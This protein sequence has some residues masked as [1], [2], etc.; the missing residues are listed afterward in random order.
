MTLLM[1]HQVAPGSAQPSAIS[2]VKFVEAATAAI[3]LREKTATAPPVRVLHVF[4]RL[5]HGGMERGVLKLVAGLD[6][7]CFEQRVCVL[8]GSDESADGFELLRRDLLRAPQELKTF[9]RILWLA[10]AM[11]AYKP[12]IVHSRNWGAVEAIVAARLARVPAV[13]HS[14]HGYEVGTL[15]GLPL[16]RRM[17]RWLLYRF[18]D[19]VFCVTRELRD[20]HARQAATSA[21]RIRVIYNAV[22]TDR[23]APDPVKRRALRQKLN[24]EN[25]F[26]VGA[27]GR[28][29]PIKNYDLLLEALCLLREKGID[30]RG[31]LVGDGPELQRLRQ[32]VSNTPAL[33]DRVIFLGA[34]NSVADW[35]NAM[36]VFVQPSLAEGMSNTLLEAMAAGLPVLATNAGGNPEVMEDG[37]QG[38]LFP[39]RDVQALTDHL[40]RLAENDALRKQFGVAARQHAVQD[41]GLQRMLDNYSHLY[42]TLASRRSA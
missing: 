5:S 9:G 26:T 40:A 16:R 32:R 17:G 3:N 33:V 37:R 28:M 18:A 15:H 24:L 12:D 11:R 34:T 8:R 10:D 41:F 20:F 29:T 36:D 1:D 35:L 13:V 25:S 22:D 19:T 38:C 21:S 31:L 7:N 2:S 23:F 14:E 4:T 30:A 42:K 39:P 27:V 6:A